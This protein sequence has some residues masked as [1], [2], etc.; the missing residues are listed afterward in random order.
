[1]RFSFVMLCLFAVAPAWGDA[2]PPATASAK[3]KAG[4]IVSFHSAVDLNTR[5]QEDGYKDQVEMV[6]ALYKKPEV[7]LFI[8]IDPGSAEQGDI[9]K[10]LKA[11]TTPDHVIDGS[12]VED[13][14]KLDAIVSPRNYLPDSVFDA[15]VKAVT[16]GVGLLKTMQIAREGKQSDFESEAAEALLSI[17]KASYYWPNRET[18]ANVVADHPIIHELTAQK[19][20]TIRA[21]ANGYFGIVRGT[22]LIEAPEE[23][24]EI[25]TSEGPKTVK[26][27]FLYAGQ[28]GKGRIVVGQWLRIPPDLLRATRGRFYIHCLQWL[29]NRPVD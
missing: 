26:Y 28:L 3:I 12:K 23:T 8:I 11:Y 29:S 15:V 1:M 4:V 20:S 24:K 17:D 19:I 7:E 13:L 14:K 6:R 10:I 22:P 9:P 27:C 21:R 2:P 16:D 25:E 18:T 5:R